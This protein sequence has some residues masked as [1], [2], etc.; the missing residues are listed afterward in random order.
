MERGNEA[1]EGVRG[2]EAPPHPFF[3][4]IHPSPIRG[5]EGVGRKPIIKKP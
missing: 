1:K 4:T 5:G 2:R 3:R